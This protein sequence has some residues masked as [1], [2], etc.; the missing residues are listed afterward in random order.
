MIC[1]NG[2]WAK[3]AGSANGK[4]GYDHRLPLGAIRRQEMTWKGTHN[5]IIKSR[6]L[7]Y[8][9][10]YYHH[11]SVVRVSEAAV[12]LLILEAHTLALDPGVN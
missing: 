4:C 1:I 12:F 7:L 8:D 6:N 5:I 9:G 10:K 3:L 11:G 2:L